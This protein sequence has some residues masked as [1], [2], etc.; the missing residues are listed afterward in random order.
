MSRP[1]E[2]ELKQLAERRAQ[3]RERYCCRPTSGRR[4]PGA[5]SITRR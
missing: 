4:R 1:T 2:V 3:L 5:A